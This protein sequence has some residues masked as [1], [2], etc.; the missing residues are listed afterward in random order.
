FHQLIKFLEDEYGSDTPIYPP[1]HQVF[2]WT[3]HCRIEEIKVVILGQD[4]YYKE[5]G[6]AHGLCFSV[7]KGVEKPSSLQN[8]FKELK[9]DIPGFEIPDDGDLTKWAERGVLLLNSA[10]TVREDKPNSHKKEWKTF[11]NAVI[12][13]ISSKLNNVVFMLWG[14]YAQKKGSLIDK[15]KGHLILKATHPSP[16]QSAQ[17]FKGCHHFSTANTYLRYCEIPEI[18]WN[19]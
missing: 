15:T 11:T 14:D 6:Q 13:L 18:D 9:S 16:K 8:I 10:L 19:L 5:E 2:S 17:P 7:P 4:P 3:H 1:R 12:K